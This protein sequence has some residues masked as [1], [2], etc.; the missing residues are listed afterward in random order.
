MEDFYVIK[1]DKKYLCQNKFGIIDC[2][3]NDCWTNN[4]KEAFLYDNINDANILKNY[5]QR[6][7][8]NEIFK[9]IKVKFEIS[10][11]EE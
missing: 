8:P 3:N 4:L 7:M 2:M 5:L 10:E 11:I 6:L 1:K 9:I